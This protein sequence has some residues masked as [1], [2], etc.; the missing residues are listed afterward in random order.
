MSFVLLAI[1]AF[2]QAAIT[3]VGYFIRERPRPLGAKVLLG[4]GLLVCCAIV[5]Q[6]FLGQAALNTAISNL[7]GQMFGLTGGGGL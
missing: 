4:L 1:T 7:R 5:V 3:V 2:S 6:F